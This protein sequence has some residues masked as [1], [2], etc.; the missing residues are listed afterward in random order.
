MLTAMEA[1]QIVTS[2]TEFYS[3]QIQKRGKPQ[4]NEWTVFAAIVMT[5]SSTSK[6]PVVCS[7]G[8]GNKCLGASKIVISLF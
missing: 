8:T 5:D 4:H 1:E 7:F 3:S 6:P 2:V